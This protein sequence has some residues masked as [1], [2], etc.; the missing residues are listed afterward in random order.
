M[1]P[2]A[3]TKTDFERIP[4]YD[5]WIEGT[6]LDIEY[7]PERKRSFNGEEKVGP[8]VRF[9]LGLKGCSFPHRSK[10]MTFN[11]SAKSNLYKNFVSTLVEDA[12]EYMDLDLDVLKGMEI[13]TMWSEDGDYDKLTMIRPLV[14]KI[15]TVKTTKT[16]QEKDD[17]EVPF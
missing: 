3:H 6:I 16:E 15:K 12:E 17:Q 8:C 13:K 2:P 9:K 4:K 10:W 11:Y 5:E 1:K 14:E 7:D